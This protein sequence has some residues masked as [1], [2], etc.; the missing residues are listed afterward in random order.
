MKVTIT[1]YDFDS[2]TKEEIVQQ[3]VHNYGESVEVKVEPISNDPEDML[4]YALQSLVT[5]DQLA[6]LFDS[7]P[8]YKQKLAELKETMLEKVKD[9]LNSIFLD[10]EEKVT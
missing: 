6:L 9:E 10:N 2:L 1:Y 4:H 5:Y 3:A 7:G 8:L